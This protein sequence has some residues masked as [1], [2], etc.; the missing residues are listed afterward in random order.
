MQHPRPELVP[1]PEGLIARLEDR[2]G[3]DV[4]AGEQPVGPDH[5]IRE[6]AVGVAELDEAVDAGRPRA[7]AG[8]FEVGADPVDAQEPVGGV[9]L[10]PVAV[11]RERPPEP[12]AGAQDA[13]EALHRLGRKGR[14]QPVERPG[15]EQRARRRARRDG[16]RRQ[17]GARVEP[18]G[19]FR[20]RRACRRRQRRDCHPQAEAS[21]PP[22]SHLGTAYPAC[23]R[24]RPRRARARPAGP[25]RSPRR[26]RPA[27]G[28]A[29][30]PSPRR[31]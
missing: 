29:R 24:R 9:L 27:R 1:D 20:R 2:L 28:R 30:S 22:P 10:A 19:E 4:G 11:V 8:R 31:R 18:P 21:M 12:R 14:A 3:V 6:L 15:A 17:H 25:R 7:A 13:G 16:V 5:G 26:S 23:L